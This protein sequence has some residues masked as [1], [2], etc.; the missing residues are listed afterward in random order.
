MVQGKEGLYAVIHI[1]AQPGANIMRLAESLQHDIAQALEQMVEL[2]VARVGVFVD[3]VSAAGA[4]G[5]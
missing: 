4:G 5:G 1:I 3:D 2:P